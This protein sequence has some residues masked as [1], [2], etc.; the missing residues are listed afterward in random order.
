MSRD[1]KGS[2]YHD[3][4]LV[5]LIVVRRSKGFKESE[6]DYLLVRNSL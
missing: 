3:N 6:C 5:D 1:I 2:Y 4:R